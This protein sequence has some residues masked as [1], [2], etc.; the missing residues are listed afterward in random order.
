MGKLG[1]PGSFRLDIS[2]GISH[3]EVRRR[4]DFAS[5]LHEKETAVADADS[6]RFDEATMLRPTPCDGSHF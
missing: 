3:S 5:M 4:F 1:K 2:R 6:N